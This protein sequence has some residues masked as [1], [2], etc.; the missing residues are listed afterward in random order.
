MLFALSA[1]AQGPAYLVKDINTTPGQGSDPY[2]LTDVDGTLFFLA[3][4]NGLDTPSTLWKSDG[5]KVGTVRV[6]EFPPPSSGDRETVLMTAA[7][8][9]LS[10]VF[11]VRQGG[12]VVAVELWKTDGTD[13]GTVLVKEIRPGTNCFLGQ[14]LG[15]LASA[16]GLV[17]FSAGID[18]DDLTLWRSDGTDAGTFELP[19]AV[20]DRLTA[21]NGTLFFVAHDTTNPLV[22]WKS[23]GT[24]NGTVPLRPGGSGF[25]DV[26][27]GELLSGGERL[28]VLSHDPR[29][30]PALWS[31]DGTDAGTVMV[32][33]LRTVGTNIVVARLTYVNGTAF[34]VVISTTRR[35]LWRSD[36]T[37]SG[38]EPIAT[39][40]A[41]SRLADFGLVAVDKEAFFVTRDADSTH[42]LWK[43]DG[44]A[45]GTVRIRGIPRPLG[46]TGFLLVPANGVLYFFGQNTNSVELW[47]S[48]GSTDGTRP[49]QEIPTGGA[50]LAP[51]QLVVAG[52]HLFFTAG[53]GTSGPELWALTLAAHP[54]CGGDCNGDSSVTVDELITGVNVAA[55]NVGSGSCTAFD[56]DASGD[57]TI[58][59]LVTAV[60]NALNDCDN[61]ALKRG[62]ASPVPIRRPPASSRPAGLLRPAK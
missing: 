29:S 11:T 17:F 48:D 36:G 58:Y 41:A 20:P 19:G 6:K 50:P 62:R 23:D 13:G 45:A 40:D 28:F 1:L 35:E 15:T 56:L 47:R 2:P 49:V 46:R 4:E 25:L 12:L 16:G 32:K 26:L 54:P 33:D 18:E 34:F 5:T 59:E 9:H 44:T 30:G 10:F 14:F 52:S 61:K 31:S 3:R 37:E 51:A 39:L 38:T 27:D 55:G 7:N 60:G 53:D 43:S 8:G 24:V 57:V 22:L 21:V 42:S